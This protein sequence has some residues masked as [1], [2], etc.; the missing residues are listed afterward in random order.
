LD[1]L[2][3]A[4]DASK[5]YDGLAWS[6]GNGVSVQGLVEN[7]NAS[8][9]TGTLRWGGTAQGAVDA[10]QYTLTASGL[11]STNYDIRFQDGTLTI[12]KA[13]LTLT[14]QDAGKVY[15]GLAW[16]GGTDVAYS[17]FVNGEGTSVLDGELIWGG[18]AQGAQN[19]GQYQISASGL[20]ADNYAV[21]MVDGT[22][23]IDKAPLIVTAQDAGK[24]YDGLAWSGGTDVAYSGFVNGEGTSVLDGELTWGGTAQGAQN[25][26]Q[27][28]ISA[29]GL[30]ADNYAVS[31]VDGTL[32]IDKA[33]L[34]VTANDA[35]WVYDN[36]PWLGGNG[37]TYSGFVGDE[38]AAVLTGDLQWNGSA[39]GARE[40]GE[41]ALSP[42]GLDAANYT[43][44]YAD[45][46]LRIIT[47]MEAAGVPYTRAVQQA[48]RM[49][50]EQGT[51]TPADTA[52]PLQIVGSG[53]RLPRFK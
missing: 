41:Y 13:P 9:L 48:Q 4:Q 46:Q 31:M 28:Q 32:T 38:D 22:L 30:S 23:T 5:V 15:D 45:G 24:V 40:P 7:D 17:G 2:I 18:T 51:S 12:D 42:F 27:Y 37:L 25:A 21:S 6:G 49:A 34:T 14:T 29:S 3:T 44:T 53:I 26:G 1:V 39:E 11:S 50:S 8:D 20:S 33:P 10:G 47:P 19:A 16:S 43:V 36:T 52:T 35:I